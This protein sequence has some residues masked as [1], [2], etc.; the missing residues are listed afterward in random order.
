MSLKQ[1]SNKANALHTQNRQ[2][3]TENPYCSTGHLPTT[4][5]DFVQGQRIDWGKVLASALHGIF[6]SL[7]EGISVCQILSMDIK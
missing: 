2:L 5:S 1:H 3:N 7:S 6:P 4:S